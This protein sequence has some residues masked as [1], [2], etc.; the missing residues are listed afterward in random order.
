MIF[1]KIECCGVVSKFKEIQITEYLQNAQY[2]LNFSIEPVT[3]VRKI[4]FVAK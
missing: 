3:N 4:Y 1:R 2:A